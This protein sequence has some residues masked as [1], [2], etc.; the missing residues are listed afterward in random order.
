MSAAS[1]QAS[2]R[3]LGDIQRQTTVRLRQ[4]GIA[5]AEQETIWL[6]EHAL[7]LSRLQ[8]LTDVGRLIDDGLWTVLD[9]LIIRR[10]QREPLQYLL[11]SQEFCGLEIAV[12]PAVL[13]PRPETALL[14]DAAFS[15]CARRPN[16]V[17]ADVGAGSGCIAV[18]L[19]SR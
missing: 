7:G 5:N 15:H 8:I 19:A 14:V 9:A 10:A 13:I 2:A 4:A 12:T 16:A 17:M 18:A 1:V 11:G 3:L 6:M